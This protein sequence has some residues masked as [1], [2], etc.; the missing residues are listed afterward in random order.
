MMFYQFE[1][2]T[3]T[4]IKHQGVASSSSTMS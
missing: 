1:I 4:A 2:K 3:N